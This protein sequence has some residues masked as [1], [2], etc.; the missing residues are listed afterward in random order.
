MHPIARQLAEWCADLTE[1]DIPAEVLGLV[2]LR[3]LDSTGLIVGGSATEAVKAARLLAEAFSGAAQSTVV[4]SPQRLPAC[5]AVLVHGVA[6]HCHDF[7][8][9][10]ADS[11]VHP[12]SVVIP[13]AIALAEATGAA[14]DD[15][16]AAVTVG[17]EVAARV[18]AVAGRRFHAR[19]MHPT[20][21][22]GPVAAAATAGRLRRLMPAQISW[23]M[24]L[25]ASM[26][27]GIRAYARDGGWSKWLHVGW[28]AHGG[29]IAADLAARG[30]R[31][32]E[33]VFDGGSDLFSV[34]LHGETVDRTPLLAG[35]GKAWMGAAA[36]FKYYP[37]AHVIQPFID[38]VLAV[39][40][41]NGL[42]AADIA[43]I[44]CAIAPWAAAIVCEP[45]EAKLRF[46]SE[47]EAIGS[48]PYQLSVAV[49]ERRVG[50]EALHERMRGRADIAAFAKRI[51]YRKDAALGGNFDGAVEVRTVSGHLFAARATL[52][53]NDPAK[54]REKFESLVEPVLGA[55]HGHAMADRLLERPADWQ[56][57]VDLLRA[58][59]S[60]EPN[61][62]GCESA[63]PTSRPQ[64]KSA[65]AQC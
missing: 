44:E 27:G 15:F 65:A 13:T 49:L 33:F 8:D 2:P 31:G 41:A 60:G 6:A 25:A 54:V 29:I 30:F 56:A 59:P 12:G 64:G 38:A 57:A 58:V 32:P 43:G 20:G 24:G 55:R 34:M 22:V 62:V 21:I 36:E 40:R 48:L 1:N 18:G 51:T 52:A 50:L 46:A 28:A 45:A 35:L 47:L 10:F 53:G 42:R 26:A 17:Y 16:R 5:A 19:N 3:V 11:V 37:C 39:V 61:A 14:G 7:D 9:T 23:A 4:A 63:S